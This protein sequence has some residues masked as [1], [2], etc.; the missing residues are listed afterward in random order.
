MI[1]SL[2]RL[3]AALI[4]V[5]LGLCAGLPSVAAATPGFMTCQIFD[6]ARNRIFYSVQPISADSQDTDEAYEIYLH[7]V[8][9]SGMM[10]DVAKAEGNCNWEANKAAAADKMK[11]FIQHF[12]SAGANPFPDRFLS[13]PF[14]SRKGGSATADGASERPSAHPVVTVSEASGGICRAQV[15][16]PIGM[17]EAQLQMEAG[18]MKGLR[19]F[20]VP[21]LKSALG[22]GPAKG[23]Q[24]LVH[25]DINI[26]SLATIEFDG[27]ATRLTFP[28]HT[29]TGPIDLR[30][31]VGDVV[32]TSKGLT[33]EADGSYAVRLGGGP[34]KTNATVKAIDKATV[35]EV[36]ASVAGAS[37]QPLFYADIPIGTPDERDAL[38]QSALDAVE[39]RAK[40][41][42]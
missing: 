20:L 14:Q 2:F 12:V 25:F 27:L 18:I 32:L 37:D 28:E 5:S 13:D 34:F 3:R 11:A 10:G 15:H 35:I 17:A 36:F 23:G 7:A 40:A 19:Y 9:Q 31:T 1:R 24:V 30:L 33:A 16:S 42:C 8:M 39:L 6:G 26:V 41:G 21:T 22:K 4:V 38:T 29:V